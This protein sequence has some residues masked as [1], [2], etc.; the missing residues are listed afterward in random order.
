MIFSHWYS[1]IFLVNDSAFNYYS[2][3]LLN[4]LDILVTRDDPMWREMT[5]AESVIEVSS[6]VGRGD[7]MR[8]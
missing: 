2:R 5:H 3:S 7:V 8:W 1:P 6:E 4:I